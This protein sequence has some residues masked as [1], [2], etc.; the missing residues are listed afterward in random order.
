MTIRW[1][2]K[3]C[4]TFSFISLMIFSNDVALAER[5][6]LQIGTSKNPQA[7]AFNNARKIVRTSDDILLVAYQDSVDL[8]SVVMWTWSAD[9][10]S[11][12][13]PEIL[14][15][16]EFPA[17]AIDEEDR[18]YAVW[19]SFDAQQ[20]NFASFEKESPDSRKIKL[21]GTFTW[22]VG[23]HPS[24]E[25]SASGLHVVF[26]FIVSGFADNIEYVHFNKNTF[27][28]DYSA[29]YTYENAD[30]KCRPRFPTIAGDLEFEP[31]LFYV[32][33]TDSLGSQDSTRIGCWKVPEVPL[34]KVEDYWDFDFSKIEYP[35]EWEGKS[36]PSLS[37]RTRTEKY[38]QFVMACA[39]MVGNQLLVAK[40]SSY[41]D[42]ETWI[43]YTLTAP[44]V[45]NPMP[46]V[47]DT[48]PTDMSCAIVWQSGGEIYYG[49]TESAAITL[50]SP[51]QVSE[52][53]GYKKQCPS[54]CYKTFRADSFDVVWTEGNNQPYKVMYR[55]MA[56][57]YWY[58]KVETRAKTMCD[59]YTLF[60]NYPNPF[61]PSTT[62]SFTLPQTSQTSI[63]LL[64]VRGYM[65][66]RVL[67]R[68][69][70]P[71][72]HSVVLDGTDIP[73]GVYLIC[74]KA[75]KYTAIRKCILLK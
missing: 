72:N 61:N 17:L 48:L 7:T 60:P 51:V 1:V 62:I 54:I 53:N 42:E 63:E 75:E 31:G 66:K 56:K 8:K 37:M 3:S 5:T 52:S 15:Y 35:P 57:R 64:D 41:G 34:D 30:P 28:Y 46:S 58:D 65:I 45:E 55:R 73:S 19:S 43:D 10:Y 26:E 11:W 24:L 38:N 69:L 71:G 2:Q 6:A 68:R 44:V 29:R 21:I 74:M 25:A 12:S 50:E 39:D 49:Q 36:F 32:L 14:G 20:P 59:A 27:E 67:N 13:Q 22:G 70:E 9:G 47:D 18:I 33:W 16:G 23:G 4:L 40:V